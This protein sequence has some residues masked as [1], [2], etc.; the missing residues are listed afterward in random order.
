[1]YIPR[2]WIGT[3]FVVL[4]LL[5]LWFAG[6]MFYWSPG[7]TL[8]ILFIEIIAAMLVMRLLM[9]PLEAP[10]QSSHDLEHVLR[11]LSDEDLNLLRTRLMRE[12]RNEDYSSMNELIRSN[13]RKNEIR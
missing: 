3:L 10:R 5:I 6:A 7:V 11:K 4:L 9:Q 1:M 13:K 8:G 2:H 12:D